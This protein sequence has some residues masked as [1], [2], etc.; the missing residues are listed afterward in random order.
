MEGHT[1]L[2]VALVYEANCQHLT[3]NFELVHI[4]LPR[5][6]AVQNVAVG[7]ATKFPNLTA[8]L[9][10]TI[11]STQSKER[12]E[13]NGFSWEAKDDSKTE[14]AKSESSGG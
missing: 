10:D 12:F 11:L 5:A 6:R 9:M 1:K 7:K 13:G 4:A 8:R 3:D 14:N 2:D